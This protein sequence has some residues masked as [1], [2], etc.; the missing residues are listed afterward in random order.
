MVINVAC[1][2]HSQWAVTPLILITKF[3]HKDQH[4]E[5]K[6]FAEKELSRYDEFKDIFEIFSCTHPF[7]IPDVPNGNK[8]FVYHV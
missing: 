7:H 4:L 5:R 8:V 2:I 3:T 1:H 6:W